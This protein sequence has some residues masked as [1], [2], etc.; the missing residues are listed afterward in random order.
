[1]PMKK[2]ASLGSIM[3]GALAAFVLVAAPAMAA[4]PFHGAWDAGA[5]RMHLKQKG[6]RVRGTYEKHDG[7][8]RGEVR[9]DTLTGI[10]IQSVADRR[11][12][13]K[14]MGS[15][16]WGYLRVNLSRQGDNF[17]G[18]WTYCG[19]DIG[20]GG[21]EWHARRLS[22]H[23]GGYRDGAPVPDNNDQLDGDQDGGDQ[24]GSTV[25]DDN[26]GQFD[27]DQDG[28]QGGD[29]GETDGTGR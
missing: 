3:A 1:M 27:G 14:K 13:E 12:Y 26:N 25:P 10:W 20:V 18:R 8:I 23:D 22:G 19:D 7:R 15:H 24:D 17:D 4:G 6:D 28:D 11:C 29:Q 9:G 5:Y 21:G 2:I 16:Y